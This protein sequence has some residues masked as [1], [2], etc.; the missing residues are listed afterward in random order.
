MEHAVK[1]IGIAVVEHLGRYL[2][3]VRG[4]NQILAG[5]SEFPGGK[6]ES[7]EFSADCAVRECREETGLEVIAE[8]MLDEVRHSYPHGEVQ[9]N[10]WICKPKDPAAV[11][12]DHQGYRWVSKNELAAFNFPEANR[13]VVARL[14]SGATTH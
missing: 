7:A 13:A 12:A 5:Y 3:G 6:C 8:H 11:S 2:V 1:Q 4:P 9:L 10:F 14:M